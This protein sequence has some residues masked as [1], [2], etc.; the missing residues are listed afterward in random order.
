MK[1]LKT[2][3]VA[4]HAAVVFSFSVGLAA[5]GWAHSTGMTGVSGKNSGFFCKNCHVGGSI[6][7]VAFE[8][9]TAMEPGSTATFRFTVTSTD[10]AAQIIAGL[11]VAASSGT[12]GLVAGQGTRLDNGEVTQSEPKANDPAGQAI[13]EFTWRAPVNAGSYTLYGA[14]VSADGNERQNGDAAAR[15]TR[16]VLVG[17]VAPTATPTS[18]SPTPTPTPT[19]PAATCVGDCGNDREVTVDEL[20]TG[21]NVALGTAPLS[22]CPVFDANSDESVTIDEILQA[23][24][25]S[26]I[27]CPAE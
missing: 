7:T 19:P 17:M 26:L 15:T 18:L 10:T 4:A 23:V 3:Q 14:G 24:N 9:P 12:L 16:E 21:V 2:L 25:N 6:P 11:D 5:S 22:G 8:G 13:W 1:M 27:G 20:I